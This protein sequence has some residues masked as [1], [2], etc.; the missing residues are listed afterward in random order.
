MGN[1]LYDLHEAYGK[2]EFTKLVATVKWRGD[3]TDVFACTCM[4]KFAFCDHGGEPGPTEFSCLNYD[5]WALTVVK[6]LPYG[7]RRRFRSY[8]RRMGFTPGARA[9][10]KKIFEHRWRQ[11]RKRPEGNEGD[12]KNKRGVRK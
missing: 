10:H 5:D 3:L 6:A 7:T 12:S 1:K 9:M 8:L 11:P 2:H 4:S